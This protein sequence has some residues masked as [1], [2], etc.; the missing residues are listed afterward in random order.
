MRL[1]KSLK[2]KIEDVL[3]WT[4]AALLTVLWIVALAVVGYVGFRLGG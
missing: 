4:A 2:K 1:S 3:F